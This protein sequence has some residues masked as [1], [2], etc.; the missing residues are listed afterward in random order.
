MGGHAF[1]AAGVALEMYPI[2][3][4]PAGSAQST[5]HLGTKPKFWFRDSESVWSLCKLARPN[6]G[7]DWSEKVAAEIAGLLGL[8]HAHY[9]LGV[10]TGKPCVLS[11]SFLPQGCSLAH[12]NELLMQMDPSIGRV[13]HFRETAHTLSAVWQVLER[14][15]C[16]LPIGWNPPPGIQREVDVFVGYL[17]L[18][19]VIGNTDRHHENWGIVDARAGT[20]ARRH[21]APTFDHASCLGCHLTDEARAKKLVTKDLQ[22]SPEAYARRARSAFFAEDGAGSKPMLTMEAFWGAAK[23]SPEAASVWLERLQ[24]LLP[25]QIDN[26]L[27]SIPRERFSLNGCAT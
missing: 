15:A 13:S 20:V 1:T 4:V 12:G 26:I 7:E 25:A 5:E 24:S 23:Q 27:A 10:A 11:P 9:D 21:L 2:I 6:T 8:P 14:T 17:M 18:D 19:A 22:F 3:E 16:A